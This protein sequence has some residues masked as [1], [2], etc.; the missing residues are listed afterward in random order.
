MSVPVHKRTVSEKQYYIDFIKIYKSIFYYTAKDF[1]IKNI[2]RDLKV[3]TNVAKMTPEDKA[4]F[5]ELCEIY[6]ID[7]E[8]SY[9]QYILET[10]RKEL[11]GTLNEILKDM[12]IADEIYPVTEYEYNMKK[13]LQHTC[14]GNMSYLL[15]LLQMV[16][17]L[18]PVNQEKYVNIVTAIDKCIGVFKSWKKSTNSQYKR[19][20]QNIINTRNNHLQNIKMIEKINI[21]A[22]QSV[23]V[24]G[25][26]TVLN[27]HT[28]EEPFTF[29]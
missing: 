11:L 4:K 16:T 13:G 8:S 28:I 19:I 21:S 7:V 3:F 15:Q 12:T 5:I 23:G 20:Q 24:P 18:Y 29:I 9:P 6:K 10:F 22:T 27:G 25:R 1:G 17:T 14:I 26:E 2:T